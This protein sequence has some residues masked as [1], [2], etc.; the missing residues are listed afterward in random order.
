MPSLNRPARL[1]RG[2]LVVTG[3]VLLA[4]GAFTLATHFRALT[5]LDPDATLVPGTAAPPTWVFYVIAAGAIVVGLLALRWLLAQLAHK[6]R[7]RTWR[8]ESDPDTGRTELPAGVAVAPLTDEIRGYPGV[9]HVDATL[10]GGRDD[11]AL[12]LV[13]TAEQDA[14]IATL[15]EEITATALPRLRQALDLDTLPTTLEVRFSTAGGARTV[16]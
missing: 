9:H 8:L 1:N 2:L 12:A 16:R 15:R 5:V 10:A 7:S 14:D 13:V 3:L 4:A 11:A 6:P